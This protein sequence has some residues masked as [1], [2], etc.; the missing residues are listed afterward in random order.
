MNVKNLREML[1]AGA[2]GAVATGCDLVGLVLLVELTGIAVPA[3]AFLASAVGAVVCFL[4]NKHIAFRDRT[5]VTAGQ[6]ARF[7]LVAVATASLMAMTMQVAA[8]RLRVPYVIAKLA[9]AA[10]VFLVWTYPAQ[11]RLVFRRRVAA[12][13]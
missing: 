5:P 6:L 4:W 12:L 13:V 9:C 7:G 10:V 1:T 8:V 3:A 11:R 2:G